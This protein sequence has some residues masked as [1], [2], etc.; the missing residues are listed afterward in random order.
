MTEQSQ[1]QFDFLKSFILKLLE[2]NGLG[3][4]TEEQREMYVPKLLS[5]LEQRIGIE[6][7][8]KLSEEGL[9][10]FSKLIDDSKT[11]PEIWQA[12][13]YKSIPNFEEELK[14][15]LEAFAVDVNES[16]SL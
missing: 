1:P 3:D 2:N 7:M 11:T 14:T 12:F 16:L 8:P 9:D 4:I 6:M 10:N 5:Q 13:W 15:I